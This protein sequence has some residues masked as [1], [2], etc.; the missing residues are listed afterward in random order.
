MNEKEECKILLECRKEKK[1]EIQK[2]VWKGRG[3]YYE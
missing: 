2:G 3:K 1:T